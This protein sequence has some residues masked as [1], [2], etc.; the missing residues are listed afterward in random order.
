ML[1][2]APPPTNEEDGEP[3]DVLAAFTEAITPRQDLFTTPL[4]NSDIINYVD[5]SAK[6]VDATGT[7]RYAIVTDHDIDE[8]L[9]ISPPYFNQGH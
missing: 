8:S 2:P 3:H 7:D 4:S 9:R 1:N 6:R 5:G